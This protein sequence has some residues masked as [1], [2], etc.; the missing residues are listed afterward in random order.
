MK[1]LRMFCVLAIMLCFCANNSMSKPTEADSDKIRAGLAGAQYDN[2]EFTEVDEDANILYGLNQDWASSRG[3]DWRAAWFGFIEGPYTGDVMISAEFEDGLELQIDAK[4][5]IDG[6]KRKGR[7]KMSGVVKMTEGEKVP[8]SVKLITYNSKAFLRVGWQWQGCEMT[9]VPDEALSYKLSELPTDLR[10]EFEYT[11]LENAQNW[12]I[13][14]PAKPEVPAGQIDVSDARI[15]VLQDVT[16]LNKAADMVADEILKRSRI[17]MPIVEK[18]G[19]SR[20][21]DYFVIGTKADMAKNG[22]S[23]PAGL[24]IPEKTDSYTIWVDDHDQAATV[25][26]IGFDRRGA[27]FGAGRLLRLLD[28]GRDWAYLNK[29]VKISTSPVTKL[30]GHQIG[31]RPSFSGASA[32][33]DGKNE[34]IG[35]GLWS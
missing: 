3:N 16:I 31:Y 25:Y 10:F 32:S 22:I 6:I 9:L 4:V 11:G 26:V 28:M 2:E 21:C 33:N 19:G 7:N 29:D 12:A 30:R 17:D 8:I 1:T 15:M 35:E 23:V 13:Y 20:V 14:A 18:I 34:S 27:L 24:T 5:V